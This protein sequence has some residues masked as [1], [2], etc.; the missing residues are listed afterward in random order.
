MFGQGT[1]ETAKASALWP[2]ELL[3]LVIPDAFGNP[4]S[5]SHPY[6]LTADKAVEDAR[7]Q[8]AELVGADPQNPVAEW[9]PDEPVWNPGTIVI[10]DDNPPA[11][12]TYYYVRVFQSDGHMAWS[13]PI[14]VI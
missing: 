8:V 9:I 13:S 12:E 10:A 14:W 2:R 5:R 7:A 3:N 11:G 6:G 4:A 1:W